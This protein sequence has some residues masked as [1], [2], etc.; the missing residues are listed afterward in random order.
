MLIQQSIQEYCDALDSLEPAPGGGSVAA[1]VGA[2]ASSLSRMYGHFSL[3]KKTFQQLSIEEK[4][5]FETAFHQLLTIKDT[6]LVLV[7]LDATIYPK[8]LAAYRLPKETASEQEYRNLQIQQATMEAIE[9]PLRMAKACY[10]GLLATEN[11]LIYRNGSIISDTAVAIV[12]FCAAIEAAVINM[13]I[14]LD[15]L[16]D[17]NIVENYKKTIQDLK[18][19]IKVKKEQLLA[20]SHPLK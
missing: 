2:L 8:V 10:Q 18:E 3:E 6:L 17:P 15:T 19:K 1:C 7:D 20:I 14:N 11:L 12:L 9:C 13:E 16:K 5:A 4:E